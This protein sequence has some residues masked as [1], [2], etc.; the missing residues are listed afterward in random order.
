MK[1][2]IKSDKKGPIWWPQRVT[3]TASCDE[4]MNDK[5]A[6]DSDEELMV[7]TECDFKC[8]TRPPIDHFEKLLEVTCL[9]HMFPIKHKLKECSMMKNYMAMG[10]LARARTPEGNLARMAATPF[11]EEKAVMSI[12]GGLAPHESR[13]KLKLNSRA[14]NSISAAT[15]RYL[16]WSE[17]SVTFDWTDHLDSI[18]K[19]GRF[20][21]IVNPLV[22]TTWLTKALMDGG[23]GLNLMYLDMFE[24][25]GL[26][27]DQRQSSPHLFYG[28][29]LGKNSVPL[30][31]VTLPVTFGD[32][33]N[34]RTEMLAFEVVDFSSPYHTILGQPYYVKFMAIHSYV[35]LKLMIHGPTGVITVEV[36][37]WQAL[38]CEQS[39][40]KL[41]TA[42]VTMA[43]LRE[44]S[45]CLPVTP[46]SPGMPPT[47]GVFK[48][49][50]DARA[51]QID[52]D[53]L[54]KIVQVEASLDPK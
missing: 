49:G 34:Y 29:V 1:R 38:D 6:G 46:L 26:T 17:S 27:P 30:R 12:Y 15:P 50:E 19:L 32:A 20:P 36:K 35:Y 33:S 16:C 18:P 28:V 41:A 39:S 8:P 31:L 40:L 44:L 9:N 53:N 52:I 48:T 4:E 2:G 54:T 25:L 11:L 37:A 24:G 42:A 21:L 22:G 51:M 14:I 5:D 43:E 7:A 10:C 23:S 47:P 13:R 3:V 45:L